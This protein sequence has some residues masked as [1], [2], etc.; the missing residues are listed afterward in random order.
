LLGAPQRLLQGEVGVQRF[1]AAPNNRAGLDAGELVQAIQRLPLLLER[2]G[3]HLGKGH[4]QLCD[5]V[6]ADGIYLTGWIE[7]DVGRDRECL[8]VLGG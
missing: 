4:G 7:R 2:A 3:V 8:E 6:L 5:R 1:S